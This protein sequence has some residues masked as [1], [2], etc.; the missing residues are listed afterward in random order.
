MPRMSRKAS[1]GIRTAIGRRMT[2]CATRSQ[3]PVRADLDAVGD[4]PEAM[5]QAADRQRVDPVAEHPEDRRQER[6]GEDHRAQHDERAGDPD[7]ADG[8]RLEQ[9]QPGQADRDRDPAERDRLAGGRHGPLD[10]LADGPAA[11]QLLAEAA[12]DEQR[13]VDREREPEHRRDVEHEDAHLDLLGDEVDERQAARDGEA[14]DEQR[15]AGR[16]ERGEDEDEDERRRPAATRARPSGGPS[17]TARR[18]PW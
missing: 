4:R 10:G 15:H 5:A 1:V 2:P 16:D 3:R 11:A 8:R 7:R 13:V 14:G 12:D 17:R 9:Q 18:S 6:Q